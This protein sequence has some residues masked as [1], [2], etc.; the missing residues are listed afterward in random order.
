M[1]WAAAARRMRRRSS[2]LTSMLMRGRLASTIST[3][4]YRLCVLVS[5][6]PGTQ[7]RPPPLQPPYPLL[8]PLVG[9]GEGEAHVALAGRAVADA[10]RH[11]DAHVVQQARGGLYPHVAPGDAPPHPQ[12]LPFLLP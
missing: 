3:L 10:R 7:L 8:Q 1:S 5:M 11:H 9:D 4:P 6:T 2:G 12:T